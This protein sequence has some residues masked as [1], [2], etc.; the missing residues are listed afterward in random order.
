[1]KH[2]IKTQ[3]LLLTGKRQRNVEKVLWQTKSA[4]SKSNICLQARS[5]D[6]TVCYNLNVQETTS[7]KEILVQDFIE[8]LRNTVVRSKESKIRQREKLNEDAPAKEPELIPLGALGQRLC[9]RARHFPLTKCSSWGKGENTSVNQPCPNS[10]LGKGT[11]LSWKGFKL[12][13]QD[14]C[15]ACLLVSLPLLYPIIS[16][17]NKES[18]S[19]L[20]ILWCA[21]IYWLDKRERGFIY[22]L[23]FGARRELFRFPPTDFWKLFSCSGELSSVAQS[24]P[25]LC[26]PMNRSTPGLPV[27]HQLPEST[28]THAH[29]VGDAWAAI[30]RL[31]GT[32]P[33]TILR[34]EL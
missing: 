18:T 29:R 33:R 20:R 11:A 22:S 28:Q 30:N 34:D 7:E 6:L 3:S 25:I 27:H 31:R 2:T 14:H 4:W 9:N 21:V 1:M 13:T 8:E 5:Y 12:G 32:E 19:S 17:C 23:G 24:C 15:S 26:D 16:P 10:W